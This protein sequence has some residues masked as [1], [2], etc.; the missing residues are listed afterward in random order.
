VR[1]EINEALR[2]YDAS[3]FDVVPA[4]SREL[5]QTVSDR[6]G[7][8]VDTS[9]AITMGSWI[10]GDRD[11]NPFVT[12]AVM[13]FAVGRQTRV[14]LGHHL[15]ALARLAREV[16]MSARLIEPTAELW[17][18]ADASQDDSPF[19]ADEPYRRALRGMHARLHAF[20][21]GVLDP[22]EGEVPGPGPHA[23]LPAYASI[24]GLLDDLDTVIESLRQHGAG[25]F[26]AAVVEPVR[27]NAAI[28]RAHLCGL[29]MRQ[30]SVVHEAVVAD[31][32]RV[33]GVCDDYLALDGGARCGAAVTAPAVVRRRVVR[34]AHQR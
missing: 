17:A 27:R 24:D 11:G 16:S 9:G 29:D 3:L 34:G 25:P 8:E 22:G 18:L 6:Y 20:A 4:L 14:A 23:D 15:V 30:N 26:A 1:D 7:R 19:R 5:E 28:F 21:R 31:L 2:Y 10:G 13:R 33:A 12:A 32:L